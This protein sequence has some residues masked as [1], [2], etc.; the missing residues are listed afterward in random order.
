MDQEGNS[1]ASFGTS[2]NMTSTETTNVAMVG[3]TVAGDTQSSVEESPAPST[4]SALE[5]FPR[6]GQTGRV[7]QERSGEQS[8]PAVVLPVKQDSGTDD[9][10]LSP[11]MLPQSPP[12]VQIGDASLF[13]M[14]PN[15][16]SRSGSRA[17]TLERMDLGRVGNLRGEDSPSAFGKSSRA[18]PPR[19]GE[20]R[21]S[22]RST[23][24]EY[25]NKDTTKDLRGAE[26]Q[27]ESLLAEARKQ[28]ASPGATSQGS[29]KALPD[30]EPIELEDVALRKKRELASFSHPQPPPSFPAAQSSYGAMSSS[31][32]LFRVPHALEG[33][34]PS[35]AASPN[36]IGGA[37]SPI[38]DVEMGEPSHTP[39]ETMMVSGPPSP[40]TKVRD[41]TYM[42]WSARSIKRPLDGA[43]TPK[44]KKAASSSS[45]PSTFQPSA[46][47][48]MAD[49]AY[50]V[51][52]MGQE[53][54]E[55][56]QQLVHQS[57]V[58]Q[59]AAHDYLLKSNL[60]EQQREAEQQNF[61]Q[62]AEG[63][64]RAYDEQTRA[65]SLQVISD[66]EK[67]LQANLMLQNELHQASL[68]YD[69]ME[70]EAK[71][72]I[73]KR[74]GATHYWR[75]ELEQES[76]IAVR[77]SEQSRDAERRCSV[78][79]NTLRQKPV[80][81]VPKDQAELHQRLVNVEQQAMQHASSADQRSE[82]VL[83]QSS[84]QIDP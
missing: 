25:G 6:Q 45:E 32:G 3:Q 7:G 47:R 20:Q 69:R 53:N 46:D 60:S 82:L 68:R 10:G 23:P 55:L 2:S 54:A 26:E 83:E 18:S 79:E 31:S 39:H 28:C 62:I 24:A 30:G 76:Q 9:F 27:L 66:R 22:G 75:A 56:G 80:I 40:R 19:V 29:Q 78:A 61:R 21:L 12:E 13:M 74:D 5:M 15:R 73:Q 37:I 11:S 58:A 71:S 44:D 51:Q 16:L 84:R 36:Y 38:A 63:L 64:A 57:I 59:R 72:E 14:S 48:Q 67:G 41:Q 17:S 8:H 49:A 43:G 33:A 34:I 1:I 77:N 35:G 81:N 52:K 70:T 4:E 50:Y 65:N 42:D